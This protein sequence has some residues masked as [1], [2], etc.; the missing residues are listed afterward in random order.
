MSA[1]VQ[2]GK[3]E[4]GVPQRRVI[5][6]PWHVPESGDFKP[7][8]PFMNWGD[9]ASNK[10]FEMV[11]QSQLSTVPFKFTGPTGHVTIYVRG[12]GRSGSGKLSP[13]NQEGTTDV[14]PEGLYEDFV[15][16]GLDK[17]FA[18]RIKFYACESG[19]GGAASFACRCASLFRKK[20]FDQARFFGYIGAMTGA[21]HEHE[22]AWHKFTVPGDE[23]ARTLRRPVQ[24]DANNEAYISVI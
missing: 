11:Y 8:K 10:S 6:V 14:T 17:T 16:G 7:P 15:E 23:R 9:H 21:Y 4:V 24:F 19:L 18:G 1:T 13:T 5:Y 12:H 22:G 2:S 3:D 20:G